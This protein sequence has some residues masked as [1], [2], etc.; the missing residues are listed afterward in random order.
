METRIRAYIGSEHVYTFDASLV[1]W[2]CVEI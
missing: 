1:T 2:D